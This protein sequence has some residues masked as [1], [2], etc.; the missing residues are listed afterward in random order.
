MAWLSLDD[1]D[2]DISRFI[3]YLI[4]ALQ[5]LEP[6]IGKAALSLLGSMQRPAPTDLM[7]QL[8]NEIAELSNPIVMVLDDYHLICDPEIDAALIYAVDHMPRQLRL[9][10]TTRKEPRFP[11]SQWRVLERVTEVEARDLRFSSEESARFLGET[12]DLALDTGTIRAL[13]AKTEGWAAGLQLAALSLE[14]HIR[15]EGEECIAHY[16]DRFSGEHRYVSDYLGGVVS[17][18]PMEIQEFL[19]RTAVLDRLSPSLC[20]AV[21]G[22]SNSQSILAQLEQSNLFLIRLDDQRNWYRY[23]QLFLDHLRAAPAGI[24]GRD[25]HLK[26]KNWYESHGF[27]REAVKHALAAQ[28]IQEAVRLVRDNAETM[29]CRGEFSTILSWLETLPESAIL[30]NSD[31]SGFKAWILYLRGRIKE[32]EAYAALALGAQTANTPVAFRGTLLAFQA[33]LAIN[34]GNPRAAIPF[35]KEALLSFGS[36]RSFFRV[37]ALSLLGHA[38]RQSGDQVTASVTLREAVGL[39]RQQGNELIT[40]DALGAL[41]ALMQAQ[42]QLRESMHLCRQAIQ[43]S[44]DARGKPLPV[45]GLAFVPRGVA[46]YQMN[47]LEAARDDLSKGISLCHQLGMVHFTLLGQ[48]N[49]ARA[50]HALGDRDEAWDTLATASQ[51]AKSSESPRRK[52]LLDV[53]AAEL[54]LRE[55]NV[56]GAERSLEG[57]RNAT[58]PISEYERIVSARLFLA[59]GEWREADGVL[60][61]LERSTL[62]AQ[63]FGS[64]IAVHVLQALCRREQGDCAGALDR[65]ERAVRLAAPENYRRVFI[66]EG[67]AIGVLLGRLQHVVPTFVADLL[68]AFDRVECKSIPMAADL[69]DPQLS[70]TQIRILSLLATG[71]TNQEIASELSITVGTTKWHLN[72]IFSRLQARN[73]IEAILAARRLGVVH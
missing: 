28:D 66:D 47:A 19:R 24:D 6:G 56:E 17:Q 13:A 7:T 18:Q 33:F 62:Q 51:L 63:R 38:Q 40:L 43:S 2:N 49:L 55:G 72:Q 16:V 53:V 23:H 59:R 46:H 44:V 9:V 32:S 69:E 67:P 50:H 22:Y 27:G 68:K 4:E 54:N 1:D 34:R 60:I 42:G 70:Q 26:S 21:T 11:L 37:C 25:L 64:L 30:E 61:Q 48:R 10:V 58:E 5:P 41:T 15:A 71:L 57:L 39:G 20:N 31:L 65:L 14:A 35:A 12:M 52:R 36:D 8:L 73:R 3:S 45:A 29:A